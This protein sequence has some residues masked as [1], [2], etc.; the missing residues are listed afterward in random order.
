MEKLTP[1]VKNWEP[2]AQPVA[3]GQAKTKLA[4]KPKVSNPKRKA[5]QPQKKSLSL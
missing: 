4:S 1:V 3:A 5:K 2:D